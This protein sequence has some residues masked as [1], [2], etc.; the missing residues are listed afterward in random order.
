M[1]LLARLVNG[2]LRGRSGIPPNGLSADAL[3]MRGMQR[4]TQGDV[5]AARGDFEAALQ[6]DARCAPAHCA[7]GVLHQRQG[8]RESALHHLQLACR[9]A[10]GTR[11]I[12]LRSAQALDELGLADEAITLLEPIVA[13]QS[14]DW[15]A[16]MRLAR[17]LGARDDIDTATTALERT[18]AANPAVAEPL[19]ALAILYRDAGRID[20]ALVLYE[21]IAALQPG[22]PTAYSTILFHELYR[23]H[24]RA[25]LAQRH[26]LWG[27]RF[28]PPGA[29]PRFDNPLKAERLLRIGYVSAD[30]RRS[31]AARFIEPLLAARDAERFHVVCYA[32]SSK[33]DAVTERFAGL[34]DAWHEVASLD[35]DAFAARVRED[36]IDIL[37]DLNGH[38][39]GN[40]LTAFGRRLAPVQ[41]TYLG[42]GATTGVTTIDYRITDGVIDPAER[43]AK[44]AKHAKHAKYY[45]ERLVYLPDTLWCFNPPADAPAPGAGRAADGGV[46][47]AVFNNFSKVS[48]AALE[49]WAE[50][51]ARL[52]GARLVLVGIAPGRTRTRVL[53]AFERHGVAADRLSFHARLAYREYL[54]QHQAVDIA[55]D[56]FPYTG[57]ATTC[58]AL[59]M[60]VPV[61][62]LAGDAVLARSGCSLLSALGL[63]DWIAQDRDDY[64]ARAVRLAGE[65]DALEALHGSLRARM[66]ASA[67]C[68]APRFMRGF[69]AALRTMWRTWCAAAPDA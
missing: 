16:S 1:S 10:P 21:R 63:Q 22:V 3:V 33:R 31:S 19:D 67:L 4:H 50:I 51:L 15:R 65:R 36:A 42:Y 17:L 11:A 37:V 8:A 7:L 9:L 45:T 48:G 56:T 28:A 53:E 62:T 32:A 23:D 40:R 5:E 29:V 41:A 57:G 58:D 6:A 26:R 44:S 24:D 18:V 35:D 27:R 47:F 49:T 34:A 61:L 54:A 2:I 30:F 38:T 59:W 46:T 52:P 12:V 69:E 66:A 13:A 60:G 43:V 20:E 55:L 39:R 25:A 64:V 14:A 68:D